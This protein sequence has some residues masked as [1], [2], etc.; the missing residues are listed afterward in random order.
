M[1][2]GA[3]FG[4]VRGRVAGD[5]VRTRLLVW[6]G[7]IDRCRPSRK[8][9]SNRAHWMWLDAHGMPYVAVSCDQPKHLRWVRSQWESQVPCYCIELARD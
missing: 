6:I 2:S 8:L 9:L 5:Y 3:S 4:Q 1:V 7:C